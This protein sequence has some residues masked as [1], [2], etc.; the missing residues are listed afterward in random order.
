MQSNFRVLFIADVIEDLSLLD[1]TAP[2][3]A[4][5][6]DVNSMLPAD[7]AVE[8]ALI[9]V[10]DKEPV[11]RGDSHASAVLGLDVQDYNDKAAVI[12][13]EALSSISIEGHKLG[14]YP[15]FTQ[16]DPREDGQDHVL[17]VQ[18]DSDTRLGLMWG[19]VGIANFFIRPAELKARDFSRAAFNWDCG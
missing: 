4:A 16:A 2:N 7:P 11:T 18:F 12:I 5:I 15:N 13:A 3:T 9:A 10:A 19:D 8:T 6:S 14:G 17:L 1:R